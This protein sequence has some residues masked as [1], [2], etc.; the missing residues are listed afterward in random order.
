MHIS[1]GSKGIHT[2]HSNLK[3]ILSAATLEIG[4]T[5]YDA[6]VQFMIITLKNDNYE[7]IYYYNYIRDALY[8][9]KIF[10]IKHYE[11]VFYCK[12]FTT[13]IR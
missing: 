6:L 2:L 10:L 11:I 4:I 3:R 1:I 7:Y 5:R 8:N 12:L 13:G 9:G